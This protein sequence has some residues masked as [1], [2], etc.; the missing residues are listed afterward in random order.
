MA[1]L[2]KLVE[3]AALAFLAAAGV[4]MAQA[5]GLFGSTQRFVHVHPWVVGVFF[6]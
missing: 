3:Q 1:L 5:L 2:A 4:A 6:P